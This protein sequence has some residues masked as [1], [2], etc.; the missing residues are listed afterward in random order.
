MEHCTGSASR[1][2]RMRCSLNLFTDV[3]RRS[4]PSASF[5]EAVSAKT[6]SHPAAAS[7]L[8]CPSKFCEAIDMRA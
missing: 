6:F 2:S 3:G 8:A 7:A 5:P 1:C 4:G